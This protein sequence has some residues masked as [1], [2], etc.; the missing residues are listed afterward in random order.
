LAHPASASLAV[1]GANPLVMRVRRPYAS[2]VRFV[3]PVVLLLGAAMYIVV[4]AF[5]SQLT[6]GDTVH[7]NLVIAGGWNLLLLVATI[8]AVVDSIRRVRAKKTRQLATDAMVVKLAATPFFVLNFL[9]LAFL[10]VGGGAIFILGGF[11][12]WVAFAIGIALTYLA[13][14]STSVYAWA[15]IAQLRRDRMIGIWLTVVYT[16][17]S[18]VPVTDV[19]AGVLLFGHSRR[20]PRLALVVVLLSAGLIM[21]ALGLLGLFGAVSFVADLNAGSDYGY[22]FA[23]LGFGPIGLVIVGTGV[24]VATVV[25]ISVVRRST[26]RNQAQRAAV[27]AQTSTESDI[28]DR[29]YVG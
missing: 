15:A 3:Q 19:A 23:A 9:L 18:L 7:W 1:W 22:A 11:L 2:N 14:L 10:F 12:L 6:R 4:F 28:S 26:L 21:I 27:A 16:I 17:L 8:V 5:S 24:I 29:E 13:L 25:V 20:R